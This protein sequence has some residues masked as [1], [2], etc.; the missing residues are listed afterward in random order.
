MCVEFGFG[1]FEFDTRR[2]QVLLL[3]KYFRFIYFKTPGLRL[4]GRGFESLSADRV[5]KVF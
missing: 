3:L 4:G 5:E 2:R 1:D